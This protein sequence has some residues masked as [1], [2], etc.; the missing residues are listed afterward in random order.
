V[1][2]P[3][4]QDPSLPLLRGL[5]ALLSGD[6]ELT[7]L[8]GFVGVFNGPPEHVKGD[9][10]VVGTR[11]QTVPDDVH[12]RHGRQNIVQLD[13]WTTSRSSIPGDTIGARLVALLTRRQDDLDPL[14]DGHRVTMIVWEF[15]QSLDDPDREVRH[16]T[17]RFRIRTSQEDE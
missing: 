13:T 16:R 3:V 6:A 8:D 15:S 12:G 2:P 5:Y 10:V 1:T 4:A 11:V 14:V 7:G 9:Y 17:D